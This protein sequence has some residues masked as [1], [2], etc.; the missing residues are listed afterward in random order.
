MRE[1]MWQ[2]IILTYANNPCRFTK[3]YTMLKH[4]WT[5]LLFYQSCS[6]M[7]TVLLQGCWAN[8][9]VIACDIFTSIIMHNKMQ[10]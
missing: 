6:I 8:N 10:K 7:L 4:D 3:L 1:I 5:I 9:P 2:K